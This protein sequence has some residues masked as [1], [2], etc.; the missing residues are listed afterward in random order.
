MS[1]F[2]KSYSPDNVEKKW[3]P[4]W[5][6]SKI[7]SSNIK[8]GDEF[9]KEYRENSFSIVIPPPN[10]TGVLHMGHALNSTLQDVLT[11]YHRIR[12]LHTL[13]IPGM[14]HAGI[15]T[16]S[17]VEKKL[18]KEKI[19]R[20]ELGR[21]KFL[22]KVWQWKEEQGGIIQRQ[23]REM[24]HSPDWDQ[25][26]FTLDKGLSQ[27]VRKV[28]VSLYKEGLIYKGKRIVNWCPKLRTALSD[29][30]VNHKELKGKLY[31]IK[32]PVKDSSR[33]ILIATTR[34]ET[35][36]GDTAIAFH[37]DDE[38]YQ[39]L[40]NKKAILPLVGREIPFVADSFVDPEFGTGLVKVTP[41]HDPNDFEI[42]VRHNLERINILS[43]EGCITADGGKYEGLYRFKARERIV[44]DL[45][46]LG[47]LEKITDHVHAVGHCYRTG[48]IVE[49]YLTS[50]WFVKMAPLAK[51]AIRAVEEGRV[52]FVPDSW[53]KTYL[54][55]MNNI[56][57]WC[58]SRQLW[59]GHR[60][61]AWYCKDCGH[62]TVLEDDPAICEKCSSKNI[63]QDEDVLDTWFSSAL[64]PF[65]TMGW[66][67]EN[68]ILKTYYPTSVLVTAFDIIFFWVARMIMMGIK[69]MNDV[70]FRDV[71]IH[72]LVLDE[73]GQ[74]QSKSKGNVINPL[75]MMY[76]YGTDAFRFAM[77]V[78]SGQGRG[79]RWN[80]NNVSGF[81]NFAN[82]IWNASRFIF[83]NLEDGE[84]QSKN[85]L[86]L[87]APGELNDFDKWILGRLMKTFAEVQDN[88]EKYRL[89]DAAL[90]VYDFIW[91]EYCD[92]YIELCKDNL[93]DKNSKKSEN[94]LRVLLFVLEKILILLHPFMP[95]ISEEIYSYIRGHDPKTK[96]QKELFLVMAKW[97][98]E[99]QI[100][101]YIQSN[102]DSE[103]TLFMRLV[104][105]IRKIRGEMNIAPN[106]RLKATLVPDSD[107]ENSKTIF[108]NIIKNYK[109]SIM[110]LSR[111]EDIKLDE[112]YTAG[113][114]DAKAALPGARVIIPLEGIIDLDKERQR[115]N[116]ELKKIE[117]KLQGIQ[118]KLK[119]ESFVSKAPPEIVDK[120][121]QKMAELQD[122]KNKYEESLTA[123]L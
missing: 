113:S 17:V 60:I 47:L 69:F 83:L 61:P 114:S 10:V 107:K 59:W 30:E 91:K 22:E 11:R 38:R 88:I 102:K 101:P 20:S 29:E 115:L 49:P 54:H 36:L 50:Q 56:R 111:L 123:I 120:E 21:E 104:Y 63:Y 121:K 75:D 18:D 64:W 76:K 71:L 97:P 7:F 1:D 27:A 14:D 45:T 78:A 99:E 67:N 33:H 66:P 92:W 85:L 37:P 70:P 16:Q 51:P 87:P 44:E 118:A 4:L 72:G 12:G 25:E 3:Y 96:I 108:S 68:S 40:K 32:Y 82:K 93:K 122:L 80:E 55:W 15:A 46:E 42:G 6:N 86:S 100:R 98:T 35:M 24:G 53:K 13:W 112:N 110:T 9:K 81:R 103:I 89:A 62:I 43:P 23:I 57:D 26:R 73:Y 119:N 106:L 5:E 109:T 34:P 19:S 116:K 105:Q 8:E 39:E 41:A 58:I 84:I 74:K 77:T 79:I 31:Y 2:P 52:R 65:S 117:A 95:F 90:R 28:F 94:T 48:D